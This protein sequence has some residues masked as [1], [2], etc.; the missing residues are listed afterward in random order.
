MGKMI[1]NLT[2]SLGMY[3]NYK[4]TR[5]ETSAS[6]SL[7]MIEASLYSGLFT[8]ILKPIVGEKRPNGNG[9]LS[10]PSGHTTTAFAFA[11]AIGMEHDWK[12]YV[13]AYTL[14]T[15]VGLSRINDNKH[16][17]HDVVAGAT[18][19]ISYAIAL[20]TQSKVHNETSV[21]V[22]LK[23]TPKNDGVLSQLTLL[24]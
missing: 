21:L 24:Y 2:Y 6:R 3:L 10:F 8:T 16:Y 4:Y 9:N 14:A 15:V 17:L 20:H 5:S 23:P 13:P 19:G 18:I 11:A 12:Y 22:Y 1:P 7:Y